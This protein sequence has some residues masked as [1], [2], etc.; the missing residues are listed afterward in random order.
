MLQLIGHRVLQSLLTLLIVSILVFVGTELLPGDLAQAVLGQYATPESVQA[1][2][3][4]L[5]LDRPAP[6]RYFEWLGGMI[7]LD[8]GISLAQQ[9]PV[10]GLIAERLGRTLLLAGLSA[11]FAVPV[12]LGIGLLRQHVRAVLS[13]A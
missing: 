1:L 11:A 4:Q 8:F 3:S 5:G 13:I 7:R 12:A 10:S 6:V 2:R 9:T